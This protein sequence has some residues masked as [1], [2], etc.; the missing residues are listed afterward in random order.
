VGNATA[1]GA[2]TQE[3]GVLTRGY[4][5]GR[6]LTRLDVAATA[7]GSVLSQDV[8]N[9]AYR[10]DGRAEYVA[11]PGGADHD[12]VYDAL[13]RLAALREKV[14]GVW[15]TTSFEYD[16][17]GNPT[18]RGRPNGMREEWER[19]AYGRV[20]RHRALR[21][22]QLEGEAVTIW[23]DGRPA[24]Y[25]DS[26]R[27]TT[28]VYAYDTAGRLQ[29]ILFGFGEA[30]T[31]EHDLRSRRTAEIYALPGQGPVRRLDYAYDLADRSV[32]VTAD[33]AE[34]LLE[35]LYA[36]G[37]LDR[38]RYGNGLE[39]DYR[40]D[41]RSG[42]LVATLTTDAA[43]QVVEDT[44]IVRAARQDPIRFAVEV[45]TTTPLATTREEYWLG[46][47]GSLADPD[48]R[49]G[50]RVWHWTDG[51]GA[52]REFVYD[53]L[54]NAIDNGSGDVFSY[55]PESNRLLQATLAATGE[56]VAYTWDAAGFAT[57]RSGL[58]LTWTATG[59]LSS[60]DDV[61][62][63]WDLRGRPISIRT[64]SVARDFVFFGG[65]VGSDPG[66]GA[67]GALDLGAVQLPFGSPER[68]YRHRDFR[69]NVSFVSDETGALRTHYQYS[70][71]AREAAFG[72]VLDERS[73]A[74]RAAVGELMILGARIYDPAVGRFLSP[75]PVFQL[76]NPYTYTFGNPISWWDPD[77]AHPTQVELRRA[78]QD[79]VE[80]LV[81]EA[82]FFTAAAVLAAR[83]PG[84]RTFLSAVAAANRLKESYDEALRAQQAYF[85]SLGVDVGGAASGAALGGA[86]LP[87]FTSGPCRSR[88]THPSDPGPDDGLPGAPPPSCAPSSLAAL[89]RPGWL[90]AVLLPLQLALGLA[91]LRRRSRGPEESP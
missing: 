25:S 59:R 51:D 19:D 38:T 74:G 28:E 21:D 42:R 27:G 67:L 75:D 64:G 46:V 29:T 79:A 33:G 60:W 6:N 70:A 8:V 85:A 4:D 15:Q 37:R 58:P 13:G 63:E 39:R 1:T 55:N 9:V 26:I 73:F 20:T 78:Y 2:G 86:S 14:D 11:R 81:G 5:A 68:L 72:A 10:S 83:Y 36:G 50:K 65:A 90:L 18:A 77:G 32:R 22:G 87:D 44:A 56:T 12:F 34:P 17:A 62:I 48:L 3:G 80:D 35:L 53:A 54:S 66:T 49:V 31:L 84:P 91:L 52:S 71:Y 24:S 69:G 45:E 41:P 89:P 16:A 40:Y 30:L 7:A 88:C 57:S 23:Q 61:E 43:G 82:A 76:L 47:G